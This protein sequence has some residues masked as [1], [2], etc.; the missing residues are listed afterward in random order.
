MQVTGDRL[1]KG[2]QKMRAL[3]DAIARFYSAC[4]HATG[5]VCPDHFLEM[6]HI[7]HVVNA[8]DDALVAIRTID[9]EVLEASDP[10]GYLAT[11]KAS[12]KGVAV[13]ALTAPRNNAVHHAEVIDPD[14]ARAIGPLDGG[15]CLIFPKWKPRSLLPPMMFQY[16]QGKKKGQDHVELQASY[17]SAASGRLILDTLMDAFDFFDGC[18]SRLADRDDEGNLRGFPL[19]PLPVA[20]YTRLMPDWPDQETVDRNIRAEVRRQVPAGASREITGWLATPVGI[21]YCG[22]TEA[23]H[24]YRHSF[25]EDEDQVRDDI[26]SGYN[27]E[28]VT[29]ERRLPVRVVEGRLQVAGTPIQQL[30]LPD[31]TTT[32]DPWAGWWELCRSDAAYYRNQRRAV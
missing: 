31:L 27:Y 25:T 8:L 14:L 17:D 24:G 1:R 12:T 29:G 11:R 2:Q 30:D 19:A 21:V 15:R 13:R 18:D 7:D 3:A 4:S 9:L 16:A 26:G 32:A 5:R 28:V 23:D 20:G 6:D 10:K 22:Y